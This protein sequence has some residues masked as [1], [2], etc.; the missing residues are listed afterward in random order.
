MIARSSVPLPAPDVPVTTMTGLTVE[1]ANQ[2]GAL[3][4][5]QTADGLRLAD[6]AHVQEPRRL[7]AAEFRYGHQHVEHLRRRDVL[8]RIAEDLL[9]RDVPVFQVLLQTRPSNPDVVRTLQRFHTLVERPYR[10]LG[11]GL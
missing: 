4:I 2:L 11:L 9:D 8:R 10:C 5:G 3:P 7:D 1:E 6:P